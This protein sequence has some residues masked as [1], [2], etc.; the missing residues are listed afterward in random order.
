MRRLIIEKSKQEYLNEITENLEPRKFRLLRKW[1]Y[2]TGKFDPTKDFEG[3]VV[4]DT[5]LLRENHKMIR[6]SS[7][8]LRAK[9]KE[10][11]NTKIEVEY[12]F[13]IDKE[14]LF[15]DFTYVLLIA[16]ILY[17]MNMPMIAY[18]ILISMI[19][20]FQL[21]ALWYGFISSKRKYLDFVKRNNVA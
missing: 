20:V 17:A 16:T 6:R 10:I 9:I 21:F 3:S 2:W 13:S 19:V 4:N 1:G 18:V 11:E 14:A 8:V 7:P 15:M 12:K 5:F